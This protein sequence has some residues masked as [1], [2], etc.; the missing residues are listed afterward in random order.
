MSRR[1][2]LSG[3]RKE[4]KEGD[5]GHCC[6]QMLKRRLPR[7]ELLRYSSTAPIMLV[8]AKYQDGRRQISTYSC[9]REV[10]SGPSLVRTY[11]LVGAID[12]LSLVLSYT[13]LSSRESHRWGQLRRDKR[14][15]QKH[16]IPSRK[17]RSAACG[18]P[19]SQIDSATSL[20]AQSMQMHAD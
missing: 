7:R 4:V 2:V 9:T 6:R 14:F 13:A 1:G 11:T 8:T 18:C 20:S 19:F 15:R 12:M 3:R 5:D 10:L 17:S 16:V